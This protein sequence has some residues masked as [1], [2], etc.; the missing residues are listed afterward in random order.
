MFE[1]AALALFF[2]AGLAVGV[3]WS[4]RRARRDAYDLGYRAG[5]NKGYEQVPVTMKQL[6]G[7]KRFRE[8]TGEIRKAVDGSGSISYN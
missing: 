5:I 6:L 8:I 7:K 1:I 4:R 3:W 2:A